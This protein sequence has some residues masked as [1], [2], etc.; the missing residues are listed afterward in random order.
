M[1]YTS[2]TAAN[3][4]DLLAVLATFA[5]AN[6]WTILEQSDTQVYLK[7][8]GLAGLDEI[9][10]GISA[11]ENTTAGYYNWQLTGSWGYRSGRTFLQ[12]PG[13]GGSCY[14]YLWNNEIPYW[15]F[16]TP[17]RI[18]VVAKIS[19]YYQTIHLGLLN[20]P[21]TDKQ[22][23]Y[24]LMIGGCGATSTNL[25]SNTG[26][27]AFWAGNATSG[28]ISTASGEWTT[29][30]TTATCGP[31]SNAWSLK[32]VL[33]P[34]IDDDTRLLDQVFMYDL[35]SRL[36]IYGDI[37]GLYRVSGYNNS[38]ETII[39]VDGVNYLVVPDCHR[40]TVGDYCAIRMN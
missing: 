38:A 1:A 35:G 7:G 21:A 9:Y 3:Y 20:P 2:G 4:K 13:N 15:M 40:A 22:Y 31:Y 39:P 32:N 34:S 11:F 25:W 24:P 19:T 5:A 23:P 27:S 28:I 10:C 29:I 17:R 8:E 14:C 26:N 18:I 16:A 36:A 12:H 33:Y 37:D 6:G 30:A